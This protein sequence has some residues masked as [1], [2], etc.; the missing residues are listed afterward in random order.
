MPASNALVAA[1]RVPCSIT[2][3]HLPELSGSTPG[4]PVETTV[5]TGAWSTLSVREPA[6]VIGNDTVD[7]ER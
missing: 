2:A 4:P 7:L 6:V 3:N 1:N 5:S